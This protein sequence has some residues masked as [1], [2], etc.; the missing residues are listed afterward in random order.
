M[1]MFQKIISKEGHLPLNV[2][3]EMKSEDL[4]VYMFL[5]LIGNLENVIKN[6]S[7]KNDDY[8]RVKKQHFEN[9]SREENLEFVEKFN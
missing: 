3:K 2:V 4:R 9:A 6:S 8:L 1:S 5:R 7:Y